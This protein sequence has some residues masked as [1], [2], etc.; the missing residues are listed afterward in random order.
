MKTTSAAAG[1][2]RE[3]V[4]EASASFAI[5]AGVADVARRVAKPHRRLAVPPCSPARRRAPA[6]L[7]PAPS[8]SMVRPAASYDP[9][10]SAPAPRAPRARSDQRAAAHDL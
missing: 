5:P 6:P 2:A 1:G 3:V 7:W 9:G 10:D 8:S 4:I